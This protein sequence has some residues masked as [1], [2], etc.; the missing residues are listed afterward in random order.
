[1]HHVGESD[2]DLPFSR[3]DETGLNVPSADKI[4][5]NVKRHGFAKEIIDDASKKK[6]NSY[7]RP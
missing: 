3:N 4:V 1:V 7:H 6:L 5:S 2:L